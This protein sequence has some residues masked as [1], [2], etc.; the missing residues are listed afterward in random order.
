MQCTQK[1]VVPCLLRLHKAKK[2]AEDLFTLSLVKNLFK[3]TFMNSGWSSPFL[4]SIAHCSHLH[5][6]PGKA[7]PIINPHSSPSILTKVNT[8]LPMQ[9]LDFRA[10]V[11][12][13]KSATSPNSAKCLNHP[14]DLR[15]QGTIS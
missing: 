11:R 4:F 5:F 1:R 12:Y 15:E 14:E 13:C 6:A 3:I 7:L 9:T 2:V 8:D 10:L